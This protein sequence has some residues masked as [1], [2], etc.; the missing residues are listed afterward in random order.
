MRVEARDTFGFC[1][2][3]ITDEGT[4]IKKSLHGGTDGAEIRQLIADMENAAEILRRVVPSKDT[5]VPREEK[6]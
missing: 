1:D 6:E 5:A 3:T 2:I 4:Q